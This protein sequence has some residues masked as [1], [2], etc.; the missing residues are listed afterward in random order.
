MAKGNVASVFMA[1][2]QQSV[3]NSS[4]WKPTGDLYTLEEVCG[5]GVLGFNYDDI[6]GDVAEVTET[7]FEDGSTALRITVT[8]KDGQTPELKAGKII[9]ANFDEGDTI[10]VNLI[11]GQ[12][13][14]KAGQSPIVRYNCWESEEEKKKYLEERD[15]A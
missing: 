13:L 7:E 10:P 15:A 9:Q 3:F 4:E 8:L 12:M 5:T 1:C 14:R 6:K 11:Y 2:A